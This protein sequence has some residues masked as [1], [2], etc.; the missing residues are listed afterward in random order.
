MKRAADLCTLLRLVLAPVFAW[1]VAGATAVPSAVP[2]L[3]FLIAAISDFA[4]GRLARAAGAASLAGRAFDHVADALFL[5]PALAV[6]AGAGRIPA[7]LPIAATLAF[8]LYLADGWQQGGGLRT[9]AL[10]PS[11]FG[12]FAGVANYAVAGLAVL[13]LVHG[14][15]RLDGLV[16]LAGG[17]AAALNGLAILERTRMLLR[18][19]PCAR[20]D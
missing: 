4:D 16:W 15:G 10:R 8:A 20:R 2:A 11:R 18:L 9:I 7:L 13:T 1:M 5:F 12:A 17:L 14:R 3:L 6:L 19:T